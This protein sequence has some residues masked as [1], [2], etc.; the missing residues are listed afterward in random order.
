[1]G[2]EEIA[3]LFRVRA[4]G[5]PVSPI[6]MGMVERRKFWTYGR[7]SFALERVVGSRNEGRSPPAP[8]PPAHQHTPPPTPS[9]T[10]SKICLFPRPGGSLL[11]LFIGFLG[12]DRRSR[13]GWACRSMSKPGFM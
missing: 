10:I 6:L 2:T 11:Y 5:K 3:E 13:A 4:T 12:C 9:P 1:M 8:A 7:V